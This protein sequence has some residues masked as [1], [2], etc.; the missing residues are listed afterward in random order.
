[1]CAVNTPDTDPMKTL[2]TVVNV[3]SFGLI[4]FVDFRIFSFNVATYAREQAQMALAKPPPLTCSI[5]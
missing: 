1:M 2:L 4:L 5:N 3:A